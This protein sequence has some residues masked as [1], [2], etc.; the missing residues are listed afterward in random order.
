MV[1]LVCLVSLGVEHL[2]TFLAS[3]FLF[4]CKFYSGVGLVCSYPH[5]TLLHITIPGSWHQR[6]SL[7]DSVRYGCPTH[8]QKLMCDA[9]PILRSYSSATDDQ[10]FGAA[11]ALWARQGLAASLKGQ[12]G[13]Q[14]CRIRIRGRCYGTQSNGCDSPGTWSPRGN[15]MMSPT[16]LTV[17]ATTIEVAAEAI[18]ASRSVQHRTSRAEEHGSQPWHTS[19]SV[20]RNMH[21]NRFKIHIT[22]PQFFHLIAHPQYPPTTRRSALRHRLV[23]KS[24]RTPRDTKA[25]PCY[26]LSARY[27][28]GKR[29]M[30]R[31]L[32]FSAL[33][34]TRGCRSVVY[35]STTR[36]DVMDHG[37]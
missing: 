29:L 35:H 22:T 19:T 3:F 5:Q 10:R 13:S 8:N 15:G 11:T 26:P 16:A 25:H 32:P 14:A 12:L 9:R 21:Q 17:F 23:L 1:L 28:L 4:S 2:L 7:L 6:H 30:L 33:V 18:E 27:N 20:D 36:D 34:A 31:T 24:H 37:L